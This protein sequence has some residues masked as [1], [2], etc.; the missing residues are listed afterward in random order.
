MS[1]AGARIA[2]PIYTHSRDT[3][4]SSMM[5]VPDWRITMDTG[6]YRGSLSLMDSSCSSVALVWMSMI[7]LT[8]G[9]GT[10]TRSSSKTPRRSNSAS[11]RISLTLNVRSI[12]LAILVTMLLVQ[13]MRAA[14]NVSVGDGAMF[15]PPR[16]V[17][18]SV[19]VVTSRVD[20]SVRPGEVATPRK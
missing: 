19:T 10:S 18:S 20:I 1:H 14:I 8:V 15:V 9:N 12:D 6:Q 17:G 13:P 7:N 16:S 3:F 4:H 2:S 5:L 11:Q